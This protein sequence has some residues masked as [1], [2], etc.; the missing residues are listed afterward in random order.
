MIGYI[1]FNKKLTGEPT[2]RNSHGGF[3]EAGAENKCK[4]KN[5]AQRV[6]SRPYN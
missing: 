5:F 2:A 4:K 1:T 6:S 3:D